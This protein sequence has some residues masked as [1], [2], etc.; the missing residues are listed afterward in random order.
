LGVDDFVSHGGARVVA[1]TAT[2]TE[3]GSSWA[4]LLPTEVLGDREDTEEFVFLLENAKEKLR[5]AYQE[6]R[7][8][9]DNL[10]SYESLLGVR[11]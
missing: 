8:R 7:K 10:P 2:I 1:G 11:L 6:E 4:A 5:Q 3:G 9:S